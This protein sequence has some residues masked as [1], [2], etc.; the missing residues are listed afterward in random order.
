MLDFW[1]AQT[2]ARELVRGKHTDASKPVTVAEALDDYAKDLA[3][4]GGLVA[5]AHRVRQGLTPVMLERPVGL[6]VWR[7][8]RRWRDSRLASVSASTVTRSAKRSPARSTS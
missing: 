8:L 3:A 7:E 1:T 6:L 2:R 5:H 4:R